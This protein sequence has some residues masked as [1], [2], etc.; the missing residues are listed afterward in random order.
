V[1]AIEKYEFRTCSASFFH[2]SQPSLLP[3]QLACAQPSPSR[4]RTLVHRRPDRRAGTA[5][6][7]L[8]SSRQRVA[9]A[10]NAHWERIF[11]EKFADPEYYSFR[12]LRHSSPI[13]AF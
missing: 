11:Q 1:I 4:F 13:L 5:V 6:P 3:V 7:M 10:N 2:R 8:K 9:E 12:L